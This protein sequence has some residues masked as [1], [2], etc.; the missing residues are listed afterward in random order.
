MKICS[1]CNQD[2]PL[3]GFYKKKDSRDGLCTWCT[4]CEKLKKQTYYTSN[5]DL[6]LAKSKV[7]HSKNRAHRNAACAIYD[8]VHADVLRP[9]RLA[10]ERL[11]MKT[12]V[13]FRMRR[14]LRNRMKEILR[15]RKSQFSMVK[16]LGCS[17]QDLRAHLQGKFTEGMTW[18]NYGK[19]HIDHIRPLAS[20]DL[21]NPP[22]VK[23][24]FHFTNLQPLWATDNLKK[25]KRYQEVISGR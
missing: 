20:F 11:R 14:Y 13:Q 16:T 10:R 25:G 9:K 5:R 18:D 23:E 17:I 19:W 15:D 4:D 12:D 24:A 8:K 3:T 21:K 2:K 22:E 7:Y 1:K 6:I